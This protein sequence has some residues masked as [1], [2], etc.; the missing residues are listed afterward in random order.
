MAQYPE[1]A[2]DDYFKI[3]VECHLSGDQK[4]YFDYFPAYK[5]WQFG[6]A[7]TAAAFGA[8]PKHHA[9]EAPKAKEAPKAPPKPEMSED[10]QLLVYMDRYGVDMACIL[11]E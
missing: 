7:M 1:F 9:A 8:A 4:K 6:T 5:Q 3:D 10:E 2:K 11:P